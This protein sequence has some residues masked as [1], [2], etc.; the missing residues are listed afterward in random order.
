MADINTELDPI[1]QYYASVITPKHPGQFM[2]SAYLKE[3]VEP[4]ILQ[5]SVDDTMRRLPFL[6]GRLKPKFFSY[7]H[8]LLSSPP[9]IVWMDKIVSD[10]TFTDYYNKG[11]KHVLRVLY[12][13]CHITLEVIH[14][15]VDGRGLARVMQTLLSRYFELLGLDFDKSDV[16]D[17]SDKFCTEEWED[18]YLRFYEPSKKKSGRITEEQPESYH[19]KTTKPMPA[20]IILKS[21]DLAEIKQSAKEH[22]AT[23]SEYMTAQIF[24]AIAD[25]R[26]ANGSNKPIT[27]L[28]PI[29]C[30]AFFPTKTLRSFVD[31]ITITMPETDDMHTMVAGIR[32]QFAK[33]TEGF[34]QE[35]IN[36]FQGLANKGRFLPRVIK[37]WWLRRFEGSEGGGLTTTFSNL[38]KVPLPPEVEAKVEKIAFIIDAE[39]EDMPITFASATVGNTLTLAITLCQ[40][41]SGTPFDIFYL[42]RS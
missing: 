30:R 15:I 31:S 25:E 19:C 2:L 9:K 18:A 41:D 6:C 3:K 28:I 11:D 22:D 29:D 27:A 40:R 24:F 20:H 38:G 36:E 21:F 7:H 39:E 8:E 33:I 12:G 4:K 10:Y 5:Q 26:N 17:C 1:G 34:V 23:V 37:K 32:E 35:S 14:S 42:R 16:I 13:E